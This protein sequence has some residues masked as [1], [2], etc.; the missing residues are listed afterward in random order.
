MDINIEG[1]WS[2]LTANAF[3]IWCAMG[4]ITSAYFTKLVTWRERALSAALGM[5][6][7]ILGGPVFH[8]WTGVDENL[9]GYLMGFFALNLCAAILKGIRRFGD[10]ADFW[11]LLRELISRL[12][13][14][15]L[16]TT[17]K[18]DKKQGE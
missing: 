6:G 16:P 11:T 2:W 4:S 10:D 13:D 7:A 9:S 5:P 17:P 3:V 14:R 1:I 8:E 12:V 18:T 15:Y